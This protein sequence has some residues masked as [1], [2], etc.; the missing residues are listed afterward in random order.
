M[1]YVAHPSLASVP[2]LMQQ[3]ELFLVLSQKM[4]MQ[5]TCNPK[6]THLH[7]NQEKQ[8]RNRLEM[9]AQAVTQF[10]LNSLPPPSHPWDALHSQLPSYLA[11]HC[12]CSCIYLKPQQLEQQRLKTHCLCSPG[13][14]TSILTTALVC[15]QEVLLT[16][17]THVEFNLPRLC[18][19]P[20]FPR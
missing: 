8:F 3:A 5:C 2:I 6:P 9:S 17:H 12:A 20:A 18:L 15:M 1:T 10:N 19:G 13:S 4:H 11:N 14:L 16:E 7:A